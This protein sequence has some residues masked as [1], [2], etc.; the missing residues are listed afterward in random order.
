M[1]RWA[2]FRRPCGT[3]THDTRTRYGQPCPRELQ[4]MQ[5]MAGNV[6]ADVRRLTF[7][8]RTAS[9]APTLKM[10]LEEKLALTPALSPRRGGSMHRARE[11]SCFLVWHRLMGTPGFALFRRHHTS[12]STSC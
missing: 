3:S 12:T 1:N 7:H 11:F 8:L 5:R 9:E 10:R 4:L 2:I 6:A